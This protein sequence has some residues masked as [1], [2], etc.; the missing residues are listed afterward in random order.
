MKNIK[1]GDYVWFVNTKFKTIGICCGSSL[2]TAAKSSKIEIVECNN[3]ITFAGIRFYDYIVGDIVYISHEHLLLIT[4]K[5]K[6]KTLDKI[7]TFR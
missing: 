3:Y 1:I 2:I 5:E 7:R 6:I 4:D